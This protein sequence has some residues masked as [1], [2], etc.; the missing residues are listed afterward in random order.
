MRWVDPVLRYPRLTFQSHFAAQDAMR[1]PRYFS[2]VIVS[3]AWLIFIVS[4]FLPATNVV[5]AS[6]T[7]PGTPLTGWQAFMSSLEVLAVQPLIIIVEPRTLL[8]LCFPFINLAMLLAPV[9]VL[10][11]DDA[12]LLSGLFLLF[13]LLPWL[14]PKHV[15][16]DL[17]VGFYLWDLSFFT[18][19]V[20][21]VLASISRKQIHDAAIQKS[22]A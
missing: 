13:G 5:A 15:T 14:F 2:A 17:F 16:G 4:F 8:F 10:A 1:I 11:W 20:G 3:A 7:P 18:M 6:G 21:C 9:V 12:W 19:L 22:A